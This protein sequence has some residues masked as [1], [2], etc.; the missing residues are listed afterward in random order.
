M[1]CKAG[2]L[3]TKSLPA[4]HEVLGDNALL[5]IFGPPVVRVFGIYH[6][7]WLALL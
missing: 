5:S 2:D 3:R 6:G 7:S 1:D 4:L